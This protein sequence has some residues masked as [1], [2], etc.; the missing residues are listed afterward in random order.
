MMDLPDLTMTTVSL[1]EAMSDDSSVQTSDKP[2]L[3]PVASVDN[4]TF[5]ETQ[6][7]FFAKS[8]STVGFSGVAAMIFGGAQFLSCVVCILAG[9]L[10]GA[11]TCAISGLVTL[12]LGTWIRTASTS[13]R[14]V[15]LRTDNQI[16]SVMASVGDICRVFR[17]QTVLFFLGAVG[18]ALT[19]LAIFV[20]Q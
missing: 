3:S 7:Q 13:L 4:V 14:G 16:A 8:A 19:I 6:R 18:V 15:A 1:G 5:D 9:T 17:F 20:R 12:I 2:N 11:V 10:A